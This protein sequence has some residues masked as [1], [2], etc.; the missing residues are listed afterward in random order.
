VQQAR[1]NAPKNKK[2]AVLANKADDHDHTVDS[3][4]G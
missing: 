1:D 2:D 3:M 4:F